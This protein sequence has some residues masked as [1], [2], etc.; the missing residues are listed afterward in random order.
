MEKCA[1]LLSG[2]KHVSYRFWTIFGLKVENYSITR[3]DPECST[4][5][6]FVFAPAV[7]ESF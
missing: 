1:K 5:K 4:L 3:D 7:F 2:L 6:A